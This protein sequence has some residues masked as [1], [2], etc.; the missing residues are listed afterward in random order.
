MNDHESDILPVS[1]EQ[2]AA[3]VSH[4]ANVPASWIMHVAHIPV[5]LPEKQWVYMI[6][7][8]RTR[9]SIYR[10]PQEKVISRIRFDPNPVRHWLMSTNN[11]PQQAFFMLNCMMGPFNN[12]TE[13]RNVVSIVSQGTRGSERRYVFMINWARK[14]QKRFLPLVMPAT[15][16]C[17]PLFLPDLLSSSANW[18]LISK[19]HVQNN[20]KKNRVHARTQL[21]ARDHEPQ[22]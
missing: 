1:I 19:N 13:A 6:S 22:C 17:N 3:S 7:T 16:T 9:D 11:H 10:Q 2:M 15:L 4:V 12:E 21:E 8:T 5:L 14:N 20:R 18:G